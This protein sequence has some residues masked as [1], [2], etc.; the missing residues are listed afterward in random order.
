MDILT[1]IADAMQGVL[2]ETA[3]TIAIETGFVKRQRKVTGSKFVQTLVFGWLDNPDATLDELTQAGVDIGLEISPQ[4]L[5]QRF[6]QQGADCLYRVLEEAINVVIAADPVAIPVLQRFNGVYLQDASTIVLPDALGEVYP[7][8]GGSSSEN[9]SSSMKVHPRWDLNTGMLAGLCLQS[10]REHERNSCLQPE[11]LPSGSLWI[12]DLGY[13]C[14]KD[15]AGLSAQGKHWLSRVNSQCHLYDRDGKL[16]NLVD[17][18]EAHCHSEMDEHVLLGAKER[19]PCRL[20]AVRAPKE[21]VVVRHARLKAEARR[22]GRKVSKRALKL[23]NWTVLC[24]GLPPELLLLRE[25]FVLMRARWQIELLFKLW[26][27]QCHV[28]EWRSEKPWRILC[29]VYAKLIG[30]IIQHWLLLS[31]SWHRPG[32]S[33]W[34]GAKTIRKHSTYLAIAFASGCKQRLHEALRVIQRCLSLG[35]GIS[36]RKTRPSTYQLLLELTGDS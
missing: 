12:V 20:L 26:K 4:G 24:T 33:L 10:G 13:F 17:F 27:D 14:L 1:R 29:E 16:W 32:R 36:K 5:D 34:K 11:S 23:A 19:L 6:R 22:K 2:T 31:G 7:G 15:Y 21:I 8:C 3:D 35:S 30:I 9:T 18:L 25:A 28:D